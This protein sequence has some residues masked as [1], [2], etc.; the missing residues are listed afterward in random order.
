MGIMKKKKEEEQACLSL[1]VGL[2][3]VVLFDSTSSRY[4][5]VPVPEVQYGPSTVPYCTYSMVLV[6]PAAV[7]VEVVQYLLVLY[8]CHNTVSLCMNNM[9]IMLPKK[10][11]GTTTN[12]TVP[13]AYLYY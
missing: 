12:E 10:D 3:T 13:G 8:V 6:P 7:V 2:C 1:L 11:G 9:M 5:A 4:R